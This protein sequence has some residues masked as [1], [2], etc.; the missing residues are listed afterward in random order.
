[1]LESTVQHPYFQL[2]VAILAP[3]SIIISYVLYRRSLRIR[4]PRYAFNGRT[5][6]SASRAAIPDLK[7]YY[8]DVAQQKVS[9]TRLGVW[10]DGRETIRRSDLILGDPLRIEF[11]EDVSV[12]DVSV[13]SETAS[14]MRVDFSHGEFGGKECL[15]L[16][17]DFLDYRDGF[18][19]QLIHNGTGSS[20]FHL[21][22]KIAGCNGIQLFRHSPS[23]A[24]ATFTH[25]AIRISRVWRAMPV[26]Y[27]TLFLV[28]ASILFFNVDTIFGI[29]LM[30]GGAPGFLL[31]PWVFTKP[32]P[33][34]VY[35]GKASN[36][37]APSK[38]NTTSTSQPP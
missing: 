13:I 9:V 37:G 5:I 28:G 16:N 29:V 23:V 2:S 6:V 15:L 25:T 19:L 30:V 35:S 3:L 38:P 17:F 20:P 14:G 1:M 4:I 24:T 34:D 31:L 36:D 18:L 21:K 32:P 10:N 33:V 11:P 8:K 26:V 7:F 22:G 12:L 27:C